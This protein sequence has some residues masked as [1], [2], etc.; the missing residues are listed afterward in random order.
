MISLINGL[1]NEIAGWITKISGGMGFSGEDLWL[2]QKNQLSDCPQ[3]ED[4]TIWLP[5]AKNVCSG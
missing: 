4:E 1:M 2:T 3:S 5:M